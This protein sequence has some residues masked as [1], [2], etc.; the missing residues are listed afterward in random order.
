MQRELVLMTTPKHKNVLRVHGMYAG[1]GSVRRREAV[2][3]ARHGSSPRVGV[4]SA[5]TQ[6][7][8]LLAMDLWDRSARSLLDDHRRALKVESVDPARP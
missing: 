1:G 8:L 3:F 5:E 4:R 7:H 6:A 2:R